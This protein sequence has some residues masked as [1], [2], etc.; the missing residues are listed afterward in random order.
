M[1]VFIMA[2]DNNHVDHDNI[3]A[4]YGKVMLSSYFKLLNV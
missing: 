2:H 4:G 3:G 1:L